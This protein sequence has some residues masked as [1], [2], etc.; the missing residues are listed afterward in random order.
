[1]TD[2]RLYGI[3]PNAKDGIYFGSASL[4]DNYFAFIFFTDINDGTSLRFIINNITRN[5]KSFAYKPKLDYYINET[6]INFNTGISM[7]D[8]LKIDEQKLIFI[9]TEGTSEDS[10]RKLH[11]LLFHLFD[12]YTKMKLRT[13][14]N[15]IS[16]YVFI[17]ELS[18]YFYNGYLVF[19][20]T[21]VL[22]TDGDLSN[23][24]FFIYD[25]WL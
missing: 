17:K 24:F 4:K 18:G 6:E 14:S 7:N 8:L 13:F 1:M 25:I 15:D 19:D 5:D 12:N 9:S 2:R 20:S 10:N 21:S 23:Y 3:Y 16:D 11:I 22:K